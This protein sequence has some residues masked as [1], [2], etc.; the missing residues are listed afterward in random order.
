MP[1]ENEF[2]R[3]T[4]NFPI[5]EW[6]AG[7][8]GEIKKEEAIQAYEVLMMNKKLYNR[9]IRIDWENELK[10]KKSK[11]STLGSMVTIN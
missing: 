5:Q 7:H 2:S 9:Y 10:K 11:L 4:F 8:Q 1:F 3:I 6:I